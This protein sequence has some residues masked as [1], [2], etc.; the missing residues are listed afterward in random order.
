MVHFLFNEETY[1]AAT[2][3]GLFGT[4]LYRLDFYGGFDVRRPRAVQA[5]AGLRNADRS[6]LARRS[7][8]A[9]TF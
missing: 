5:G 6:A 9:S 8:A 2:P 1:L 7:T 3:P 4:F